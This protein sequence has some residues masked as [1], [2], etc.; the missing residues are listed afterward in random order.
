MVYKVETW[1][2]LFARNF[3]THQDIVDGPY[4]Y[5]RAKA[6]LLRK[7][8]PYI[9]SSPQCEQTVITPKL[10]QV[11]RRNKDFWTPNEQANT[12]IL[13]ICWLER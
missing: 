8:H 7:D 13:R 5:F 4:T 2:I 10:I 3:S 9:P 12:M 6:Y 11:P 1:L